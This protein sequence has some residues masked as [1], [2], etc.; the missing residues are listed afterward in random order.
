MCSAK[1]KRS[2][3]IETSVAVL[4]S[5]TSQYGVRY[6]SVH[7]FYSFYQK[8]NCTTH[9]RYFKQWWDQVLIELY[10]HY[11]RKKGK[12]CISKIM[13]INTRLGY[14]RIPEKVN[15]EDQQQCWI[16]TKICPWSC[17]RRCI[18]TFKSISS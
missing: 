9:C 15:R 3:L 2:L 12:K 8:S 14:Q 4:R 5:S 6:T 17:R 10:C 11:H 13:F 7:Y 1:E 16:N 18:Q